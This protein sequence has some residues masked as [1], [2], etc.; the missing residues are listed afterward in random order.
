MSGARRIV[1]PVYW[2]LTAALFGAAGALAAF[3]APVEQ[4]MGAVQKIFYLHLSVALTTFVACGVVFLASIVYVWQRA[5]VWDDLA[6]A[7]AEVSVVFCSVILLTGMTW[8]RSAWGQWWTWSPRLTFSLVLWLLFVVYLMLRRAIESPDRRA[9]V[10]ALYGIVAFLDV[11]LVYLSVKLL[12]DI[13]PATVALEPR[14]QHTLAFW[15]LPVVM[16][17]VGLIWARF[18][19]ASR[20]RAREAVSDPADG[21][22]IAGPEV[23]A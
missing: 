20:L 4:T 14:M 9:I 11:P 2:G 6:H 18:D 12:P 8:G 16:L 21:A 22:G 5:R 3:Y 19:L 15:F 17:C 1:I 10:A 7:A 13:H 23:R